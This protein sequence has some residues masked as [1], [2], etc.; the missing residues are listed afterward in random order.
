MWIGQAG[1][2]QVELLIAG[3][4]EV[5]KVERLLTGDDDPRGVADSAKGAR[6]WRQFNSFR[7]GPNNQPNSTGTQL[8]PLLGG[9]NLPAAVPGRKWR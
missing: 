3:H 4:T 8:S 6:D 5:G 7:P 1:A 2:T 9:G